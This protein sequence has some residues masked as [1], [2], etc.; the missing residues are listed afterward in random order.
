MFL[1]DLGERLFWHDIVVQLLEE[2]FQLSYVVVCVILRH[3]SIV[4]AGQTCFEVLLAEVCVGHQEFI[5]A[6]VEH[7]Q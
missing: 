3:T 2:L 6:I 4:F 7:E 1:D 5:L